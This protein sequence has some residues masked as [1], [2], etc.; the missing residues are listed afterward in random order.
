MK[1]PNTYS[2]NV[3]IQRQV[4]GQWV[5]SGSY[6]GTRVMH[7][8][9]LTAINPAV[10][11]GLGPCTL[12]GVVYPTCSTT[13]NTDARRILSLERPRDGDKIGLLGS[14]DDGATSIYHGMLLS[15]ERRVTQGISF[16]T[17]YTYSRC[18]APAGS[19]SSLKLPPDQTYVKPG[20]RDFDRGNC[21]TDRRNV[22][23]LTALAQT[24]QFS[25]NKLKML[26]TGWH[27]SG[28]YRVSSGDPLDV[29]GGV[30]RALNGVTVGGANSAGRQRPNQLMANAYQDDSGRANTSW[31][32]PAA[33][34]LPDLGTYGNVGYNAFH[35]PRTWSF[36]MSLSR[37]F[38]LREA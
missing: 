21:G 34:A 15:L 12:D 7:L 18:I 16:S 4:A 20:D 3:S 6:I 36:D 38:A 35:G 29:T 28:I 30:D 24:P 14:I 22:F 32:N 26:L 23:N 27:L 11:L 13:A 1:T 37:T 10:F 25:N 9:G 31:L 8:W 33:F 5:A 19:N 2:W 17:N